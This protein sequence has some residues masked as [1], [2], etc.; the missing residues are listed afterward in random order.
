VL[1]VPAGEFHVADQLKTSD[2]QAWVEDG[3]RQLGAFHDSAVVKVR[4]GAIWTE[5]MNL[6]YYYRNRLSGYGFTL[7]A[8]TGNVRLGRG[9]YDQKGFLA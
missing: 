6:L 5:D 8:Q 7:L 3:L 9:A 4:D 1:G 2:T